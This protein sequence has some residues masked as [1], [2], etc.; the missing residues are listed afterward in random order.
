MAA[1]APSAPPQQPVTHDQPKAHVVPAPPDWF[2]REL[3]LANHA[4]RVHAPHGDL[5]GAQRA[6]Y[7]VMVPACGAGCPI[8][9]G[10]IPRPLFRSSAARAGGRGCRRRS[11]SAGGGRFFVQ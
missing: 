6:Y 8:R 5:L 3:A 9:T 1:C 4:R 7:Q 10:Q 2:H 11:G